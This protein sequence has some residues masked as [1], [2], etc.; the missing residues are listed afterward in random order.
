MAVERE[1]DPPFFVPDDL[2]RRARLPRNRRVIVQNTD[3]TAAKDAVIKVDL[4]KLGLTPQLPWQEFIGVRDLN[5][6]GKD[7]VAT[8]D[9]YGQT[10]TVKSVAPHGSRLIGLRKY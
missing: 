6:A 7:P 9:Y 10:L 5:Q 8:L 4:A 1:P 2:G 3:A